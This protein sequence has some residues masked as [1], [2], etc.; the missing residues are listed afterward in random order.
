MC[1]LCVSSFH[2]KMDTHDMHNTHDTRM[3]YCFHCGLLFM[4]TTKLFFKLFIKNYHYTTAPNRVKA[5]LI[6]CPMLEDCLASAS[7][8][9]LSPSLSY[10]GFACDW[11]SEP[12]ILKRIVTRWSTLKLIKTHP[13]MRHLLN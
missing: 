12:H 11:P 10:S 5:G 2:K 3:L 7:A 8:S 1:V 4:K 6:T 13:F 9:A